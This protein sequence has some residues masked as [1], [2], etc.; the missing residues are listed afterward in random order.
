MGLRGS[1]PIQMA[2]KRPQRRNRVQWRRNGGRSPALHAD[3]KEGGSWSSAAGAK[4]TAEFPEAVTKT[5]V[6][7]P[8]LPFDSA[9]ANDLFEHVVQFVAL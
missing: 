8:D 9:A 2:G 3:G 4:W 6:N 7:G 1:S 5:D